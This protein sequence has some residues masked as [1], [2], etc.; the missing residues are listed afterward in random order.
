[1]TTSGKM[2]ENNGERT[3]CHSIDSE[4]YSVKFTSGFVSDFSS[5]FKDDQRM[6]HV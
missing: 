5:L 1:M 4:S 2:A 3:C 6:L